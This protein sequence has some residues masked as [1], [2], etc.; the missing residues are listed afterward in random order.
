LQAGHRLRI[1]EH[2]TGGLI[3][4]ANTKLDA[5]D[6][7]REEDLFADAEDLTSAGD[8][9]VSRQ[10]HTAA[11]HGFAGAFA[12][13]YVDHGFS[14]AIIAAAHA[15]DLGKPD[16][17]F[18]LLLHGGDEAAAAIGLALPK[19]AQ[20]PQRRRRRMGIEQD[21]RLPQGFRHEFLSLQIAE[22]FGLAPLDEE[23][24][25][26]ALHLIASHHGYARPFAPPVPDKLVAE[27]R[28]GDLC[29]SGAGIEAALSAAD[30]RATTPAHRVDSGVAERFWRLTRRY[31]WLS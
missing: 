16:W 8:G 27:S 3:L 26:L 19:S 22:H 2:P 24:R 14:D 31:G 1:E 4:I 28:E 25:E 23:S 13:R 6:V 9:P 5:G 30:R 10:E 17:R 20:I 15:H 7:D 12:A 21:A 11:V 29:L 18:Q